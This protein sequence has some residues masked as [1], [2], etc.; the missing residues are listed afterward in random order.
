MVGFYELVKKSVND[1]AR[2]NIPILYGGTEKKHEKHYLL[3]NAVSCKQ[4]L[5]S[6]W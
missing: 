5:L 6:A 4:P 3:S 2:V 1:L